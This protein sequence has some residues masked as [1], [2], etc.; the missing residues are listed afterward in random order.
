MQFYLLSTSALS[1]ASLRMKFTICRIWSVAA[2]VK[3]WYG[4]KGGIVDTQQVETPN[5]TE[6]LLRASAGL[7]EGGGPWSEEF[8]PNEHPAPGWR[9]RGHWFLLAVC[10]IQ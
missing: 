4:G 1:L 9:E 3:G 10:H 6:A 8:L 7:P 5:V 2:M